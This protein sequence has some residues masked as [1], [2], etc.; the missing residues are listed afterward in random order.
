[1][2]YN[3]G[4]MKIGLFFGS[5]NPIH[6]G[7]LIIADFVADNSDIEQVWFVLSPQNPLKKSHTLLNE[8]DRLNLVNLAIAK[9]EHFKSCD[10]EFKLPKPSYTIDT[11][12]YLE[13]KYPQHSFTVIMGSD[14]FKNLP[15]WK[16]YTIL[17]EKYSFIIY[18]RPEFEVKNEE[19]RPNFQLLKAPMLDISATYIRKCIAEKKS[20]RYILP[21]VVSEEITRNGYFL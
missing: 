4:K 1:M 20:V 15:K 12:I 17:M 19:L 8:Y 6:V 18:Q 3:K 9:N 2:S 16:N 14:S 21:D 11:L 5:F 10:I 13:E 7:H